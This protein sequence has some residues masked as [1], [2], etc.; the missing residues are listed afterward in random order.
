MTSP[1]T[2]LWKKE[3]PRHGGLFT[4]SD[5]HRREIVAESRGFCF[6]RSQNARNERMTAPRTQLS[7]HIETLYATIKLPAAS[8]YAN[9]N[10]TIRP[11]N[12][13]AFLRSGDRLRTGQPARMLEETGGRRAPSGKY[14]QRRHIR[15]NTTA[16]PTGQRPKGNLK[17]R[18]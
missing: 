12:H 7:L 6:A 9:V 15:F 14:R 10:Q 11:D 17:A 4:S 5:K 2:D 13:I 16:V 3:A 1:D 8:N 18:S